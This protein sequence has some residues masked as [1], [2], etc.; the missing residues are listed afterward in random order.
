[1]QQKRRI[2]PTIPSTMILWDI[3]ISDHSLLCQAMPGVDRKKVIFL[4]S[5]K[6]LMLSCV[7]QLKMMM[8]T[9]QQWW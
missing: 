6:F 5:K 7:S 8:K 4:A 9:C 1:M 2:T 3:S